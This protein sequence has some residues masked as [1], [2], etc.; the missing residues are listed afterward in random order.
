MMAMSPDEPEWDEHEAGAA[1]LAAAV[2]PLSARAEMYPGDHAAEV[3]SWLA[4]ARGCPPEVIGSLLLLLI[5][6]AAEE[7]GWSHDASSRVRRLSRLP[8]AMSARDAAYALRTAAALPDAWSASEV[9]VC[10]AAQA[11]QAAQAAKV[12]LATDSRLAEAGVQVI[13]SLPG[14][15]YLPERDRARI[16]RDLTRLGQAP[17]RAHAVDVSAIAAG[18][19]WSD[20]VLPQLESW[21]SGA[22][23]PVNAL[24]RHLLTATGA[25]PSAAWR[26]ATSALLADP[27]ARQFLRLAL[28]AAAK[29]D[30]TE[31]S[32]ARPTVSAQNADFV[33]AVA[34]AAAATG[35]DWA[36]PAL[37]DVAI[38]GMVPGACVASLGVI[39]TP[40]AIGA[41]EALLASAP[42][43]GW[44]RQI[45]TAMS[46]AGRRA[47][48]AAEM[49]AERLVPRAG[50]DA[51]GQRLVTAGRMTARVRI[52]PEAAVLAEWRGRRGWSGRVPA[53]APA[54]AGQ[55]VRIALREVSAALAAERG[56]LERLLAAG[57]EWAVADWW[58]RYCEHPVTGPLSRGL[59][60]V[61]ESGADGAVTALPG[62]NGKL[63]T[64]EGRSDLPADGRVRLWH[65]AAAGDG[66]AATWREVLAATGREQPFPQAFREVCLREPAELA[67]AARSD[68]FAGRVAAFQQVFAL[69]G[70]QGWTAD[71]LDTYR[72]LSGGARRRFDGPGLT[73]VLRYESADAGPDEL[74]VERCRLGQVSFYRSPSGRGSPVRLRKVPEVVFS[75]VMRDIGL[76]VGARSGAW[77]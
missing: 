72:A 20:L 25:R 63:T 69:L 11:A 36:V 73:A 68:R 18:D 40:E 22:A 16:M 76:A 37:R 34:W 26:A 42:A 41:L 50:L 60:W 1:D 7:G 12:R 51:D 67:R 65:P 44:R 30:S 61:F 29:A 9:I 33:R 8:A 74:R 27:Q 15:R 43:A 23:R 56:R 10:A 38:R 58:R 75:E 14:R 59:I 4:A 5:R 64:A 70:E 66:E 53:D 52:S 45:G 3:Q 6:R 31:S 49:I 35:E 28:E 39:G 55:R 54:A 57:C 19:G 71:Y 17:R 21:P 13:A 77:L 32:G 46:S 24:I 62:A 47:G 48:L 2:P